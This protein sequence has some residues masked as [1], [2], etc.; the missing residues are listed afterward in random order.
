MFLLHVVC[1]ICLFPASVK[2][3][4]VP[5]CLLGNIELLCL[6]CTHIYTHLF[7]CDTIIL[8]LEAPDYSEQCWA[9][10]L[11]SILCSPWAAA[12]PNK[13]SVRLRMKETSSLQSLGT[14]KQGNSLV[15]DEPENNGKT[16]FQFSHSWVVVAFFVFLSVFFFFFHFGRG[17]AIYGLRQC[18]VDSLEVNWQNI[19]EKWKQAINKQAAISCVM[20]I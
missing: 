4:S 19:M 9:C 20:N 12:E 7:E 16:H 1:K 10:A 15:V 11:S 8:S 3:I 2:N 18:K 6:I 5:K 17:S 14:S 13:L